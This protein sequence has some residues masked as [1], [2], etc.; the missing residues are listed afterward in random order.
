MAEFLY[1]HGG[2]V[3]NSHAA[4]REICVPTQHLL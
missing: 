1:Q 3:N 4:R 2:G